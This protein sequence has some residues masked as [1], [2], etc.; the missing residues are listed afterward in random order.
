MKHT[1][2]NKGHNTSKLKHDTEIV[3]LTHPFHPLYG[4]TAD[5]IRLQRA[6]ET[7]LII[8]L[9]DGSHVPI[10]PEHTDF[11]GRIMPGAAPRLDID[12]LLNIV[13]MIKRMKVK[14]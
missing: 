7:R 12:G 1:H 6:K 9:S 8:K 3:K 11:A 5:V 2:N 4:Q 13:K 14:D 10:D